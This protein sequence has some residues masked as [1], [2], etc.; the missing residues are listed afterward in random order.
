MNLRVLITGDMGFVGSATKKLIYHRC[1]SG[2]N[3]SFHG[4]D[5]MGCYDIRDIHQLRDVV[6]TY[7]PNRILH[8]AAIARFADADDD[9]ITAY[10]TNVEGTINI[11]EVAEERHIPTVFASTGSVYM[12]IIG[13]P[14]ITEDFRVIGNS[15]Y[16]CSKALG[17]LHMQ[18]SA[19]PTINLRYAHLYGPEKRMHGLIGGF[20]DRIKFEILFLDV[21]AHHGEPK[22]GCANQKYCADHDKLI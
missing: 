2:D 20:L 5:L 11:L 22:T 13:E 14:P 19:V 6:E 3:I 8:L 10:E 16:G 9:P 17:D 18:Q 21:Q 4:Y 15:I 12:P 1:D 7:R